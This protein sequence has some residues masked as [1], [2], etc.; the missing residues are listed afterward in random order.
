MQPA[1]GPVSSVSLP[2][3]LSLQPQDQQ[4]PQP[5]PQRH[6]GRSR[7][8]DNPFT[9]DHIS[10]LEHGCARNPFNRVE[11]QHCST[12]PL[13]ASLHR[14]AAA[15]CGWGRTPEI[16]LAKLGAASHKG[17]WLHKFARS[18]GGW[19]GLPSPPTALKPGTSA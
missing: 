11:I 12:S 18:A 9:K 16:V 17:Q 4:P 13:W 6:F 7:K 8:L 3:L 5:K 2:R 19:H 14:G 1:R 10:A 15:G